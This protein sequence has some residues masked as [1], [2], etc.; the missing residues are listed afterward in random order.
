MT[1]FK[2]DPA[3]VELKKL[4]ANQ[5]LHTQKELCEAMQEKGFTINQS[6]ISR[7]LRKINA[8]KCKDEVGNIVYH[9]PKELAPPHIDTS[10]TNL[11]Y[12]VDSND[13]MCVVITSPG[14]A[15]LVSRILDFHKQRLKIMGCICGWDTVFVSFDAGVLPSE[16]V[17]VIESV[18]F[19]K[20]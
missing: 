20:K 9:L 1:S 19:D 14:S 18:L 10:I 3:V 7:I 15:Q 4:I 12:K 6:K 8:A 17:A 11:V 13:F 16:R 5:H 2:K